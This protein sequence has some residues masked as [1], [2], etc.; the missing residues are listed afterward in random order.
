MP[1]S[2]CLQDDNSVTMG[3][4]I[5]GSQ[6]PSARF[7]RLPFSRSALPRV[8]EASLQ[9]HLIHRH[10]VAVPLQPPLLLSNPSTE[11]SV[12]SRYKCNSKR[13]NCNSKLN[14]R[15]RSFR[16]KERGM[17][18]SSSSRNRTSLTFSLIGD[19]TP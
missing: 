3:W 11:V 14:N 1:L 17:V 4:T 13:N 6:T 5:L 12:L 15:I 2:A 19:P 10:I 7:N 18:S 16:R 8:T 9:E